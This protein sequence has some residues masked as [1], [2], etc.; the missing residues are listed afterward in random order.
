MLRGSC[1]NVTQAHSNIHFSVYTH[2]LAGLLHVAGGILWLVGVP[3][4]SRL[5]L[6]S[7]LSVQ[8]Q[9]PT[10]R[11]KKGE[12]EGTKYD[13][14]EK[15]DFAVFP[16]L[17][18]GPHNHQIGALACALKHAQTAEFK[19]YTKQ[20]CDFHGHAAVA[21]VAILPCVRQLCC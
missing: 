6:L 21:S 7:C 14:E 19:Q 10:D 11:L 4:L 13:F 2:V 8:G 9:K 20:V 12:A 18:G 15:I 17:Q 3:R 16:S 5:Q 1:D